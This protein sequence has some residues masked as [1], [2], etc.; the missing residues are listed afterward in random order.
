MIGTDRSSVG[1]LGS[2][3]GKAPEPRS[4]GCARLWL[5]VSEVKDGTHQPALWVHKG[6]SWPGAGGEEQP[7]AVLEQ[8]PGRDGRWG[9]SVEKGSGRGEPGD[10]DE[11]R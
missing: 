10:T 5:E 8:F 11:P 4:G 9:G 3:T 6:L 7:Q 1:E 2:E